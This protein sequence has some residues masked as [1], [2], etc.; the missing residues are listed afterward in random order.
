M[1]SNR[2]FV[3]DGEAYGEVRSTTE[4]PRL[5]QRRVDDLRGDRT[6]WGTTMALSAQGERP[7]IGFGC[8][9]AGIGKTG[10]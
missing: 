3:V 6:F 2:T 8:K 7:E 4:Q 1:K 9:Q 5:L 10:A